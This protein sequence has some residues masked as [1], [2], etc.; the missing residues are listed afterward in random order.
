MPRPLFVSNRLSVRLVEDGGTVDVQP[1]SGG[2]ATAL[3]HA[4][5]Q[6]GARWLGWPGPVSESNRAAATALLKDLGAHPV[7]LDD[8][9]VTRYYDGFSNGVLWP[10]FHC[11][12]DKLPFDIDADW[13]A[14]RDV[15]RRFAD[16][17]LS[18]ID[19]GDPIW[20]HDFH[21]A[22]V[23][24]E[25]RRVLPTARIGF[26]LH[27]PFPPLEVFRVLPHAEEVIV[28][29]LGADV[30]GFHTSTFAEAFKAAAAA[31]GARVVNDVVEFAGHASRVGV[32]PISVDY[33]GIEQ[34]AERADVKERVEALRAG[35]HG[36]T[37]LLGVDR[38]DYTK[39][40]PRR[41]LAIERLLERW[42]DLAPRLHFVQLAVPTR[43]NVD[44]YADF[45]D[46]VNRLVGRV[47][48]KFGTATGVPIHFMHRELEF[49]ELVALYGAADVMIV[50]PL[51]DGMNL[52]CKEYIAA[53]ADGRGALVLSAFAGAADELDGA[54]LVNPYDIEEVARRLHDAIVMPVAE[55][56]V[57]MT[58]LRRQVREHDVHRWSDG[59]LSALDAGAP[60]TVG[61]DLEQIASAPHLH[62]V[63]DYDGTLMPIVSTPSEA[64]PDADVLE[65]LERLVSTPQTTVQIASGRDRS[66]LGHWLG[67][68]PIA[69]TAEHGG[70]SRPVNG[71]WSQSS[72]P[73]WLAEIEVVLGKLAVV[74]PGSFVEAKGSTVALH[75]RAVREGDRRAFE[76]YV[77]DIL[78]RV[79]HTDAEIMTGDCVVEVRARG[80]NKGRVIESILE[81]GKPGLILAAGDDVTDQD[82][83]AALP[84]GAVA[85]GVGPRVSGATMRVANP[86]ELRVLL[87]R[88]A[89]A[90][91]HAQQSRA[92][93]GALRTM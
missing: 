65:L 5:K 59:F 76:I 19:E 24:G 11:S 29:M 73:P 22:L 39:G 6:T 40:L 74:A 43:E 86:G 9:E 87:A 4:R 70:S 25:I 44:A 1:T 27:I 32:F 50:T 52:V 58:A 47:N 57:R 91:T 67:H 82:M 71:E 36:R 37:I 23:P 21:L 30:I 13:L 92:T 34:C 79:L 51:R 10:L 45:R 64:K 55:Q 8:D 62:I 3:F 61:V 26:F 56:T 42:P 46:V 12:L 93:L 80:V 14:W 2:L 75:T 18:A 77:G 33:E 88:I 85:V 72:P 81:Q 31:M 84:H 54:L 48:G 89:G 53:R 66:T 90:R 60:T 35:A 15:N 68:L 83:F 7:F 17:C 20:L 16:A 38:L 41:L 49:D 69:L 78:S 63:L 28:G